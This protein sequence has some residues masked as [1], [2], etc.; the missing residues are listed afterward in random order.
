M[1]FTQSLG[2]DIP[3]HFAGDGLVLRNHNFAIDRQVSGQLPPFEQFVDTSIALLLQNTN[4]ILE[5]APQ[6]AFFFF[7]D[8]QG[9]RVFL[10]TLARK[11]LD[12]NDS[13][14]DSRRA[15]ERSI[16]NVACFLAE[17]CAQQFFLRSEL[18]LA[19]GR[20]LADQDR[21]RLH[22]CA[23][24]DDAAFVQIAKHVLADIGNVA[25]D[26]FRTQLGI[27]RFD[28]EL[29]DVNRSV[30]VFFHQTL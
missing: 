11:D 21:T 28:L 24:A 5:V 27:A 26:F 8:C 22:L 13:S 9:A 4:L 10:L 14:V 1:H 23:D 7:L 29:F 2:L 30:V 12:I 19:L 20:Y 16:L 17:D 3:Q 25:R 15:Y 6:P 18:S